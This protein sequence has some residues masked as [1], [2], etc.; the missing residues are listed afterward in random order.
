MD[1]GDVR[2]HVEGGGHYC[3]GY[4][5]GADDPAESELERRRCQPRFLGGRPN[6]YDFED[7]ISIAR[8]TNGAFGTVAC[9]DSART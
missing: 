8:W 1:D 5:G 9:D 3:G 7:Y 2:G 4:A 6:D